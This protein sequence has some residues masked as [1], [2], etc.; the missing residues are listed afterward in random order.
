MQSQK[1]ARSAKFDSALF[2][3]IIEDHKAQIFKIKSKQTHLENLSLRFECE[4]KFYSEIS[5]AAQQLA[6]HCGEF[7]QNFIAKLHEQSEQLNLNALQVKKIKEFIESIEFL[8]N[9]DPNLEGIGIKLDLNT[10]YIKLAKFLLRFEGFGVQRAAFGLSEALKSHIAKI[11]EVRE[12]LVYNL[13]QWLKFLLGAFYEFVFETEKSEVDVEFRDCYAK[14]IEFSNFKCELSIVAAAAPAGNVGIQN[15][16][17]NLNLDKNINDDYF[18]LVDQ[19][20]VLESEN[21]ALKNEIESYKMQLETSF[22]NNMLAIKEKDEFNLMLAGIHKELETY[23]GKFSS[24]ESTI[25]SNASSVSAL[26]KEKEELNSLVN[27]LLEETRNLKSQADLDSNQ[28][29]NLEIQNTNYLKEISELNL[30]IEEHQ[31]NYANIDSK[32]IFISSQREEYKAE[33]EACQAEIKALNAKLTQRENELGELNLEKF[34]LLQITESLKTQVNS[35]IVK[36]ENYISE[37][38]LSQKEKEDLSI[39]CEFA[40][41]ETLEQKVKLELLLTEKEVLQRRVNVLLSE[42]NTSSLRIET[43]VNQSSLVAKERDD[44]HI[45]LI[46][47]NRERESWQLKYEQ[48]LNEFDALSAK[49]FNTESNSNMLSKTLEQHL[50]QIAL[51]IKEREDLSRNLLAAK[52][53]ADRLRIQ[54]DSKL[55]YI[56]SIET[57]MLQQSDFVAS[58]YAQAKGLQEKINK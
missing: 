28:K 30:Q 9:G 43:H 58:S 51:L 23:R 25:E 15:A 24:Y 45:K 54:L 31:M 21:S 34:N 38:N 49:V 42:I 47:L 11:V 16:E 14:L 56:T 40:L 3:S 33:S 27:S 55:S 13:S 26:K 46:E 39:K 29:E 57:Q 37:F 50:T 41:K 22:G 6:K 19:K 35:Y 48:L 18:A 44:L 7:E 17:L 52:S 8:P 1:H 32:V 36:F 20:R 5:V 12:S 10:K 4:E 53:E 2:S